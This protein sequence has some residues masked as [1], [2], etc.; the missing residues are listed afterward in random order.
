[1]ILLTVTEGNGVMTRVP[2]GVNAI[3]LQMAIYFQDEAGLEV[4]LDNVETFTVTDDQ[5]EQRANYLRSEWRC[6]GNPLMAVS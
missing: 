3:A 6:F 4:E 2:V 1:M 5:E